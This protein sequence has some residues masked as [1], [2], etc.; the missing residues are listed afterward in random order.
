[1]EITSLDLS[2]L[3]DEISGVQ[4]G[5]VQKVYQ[6]GNEFT[7]RCYD[8]E[9]KNLVIKPN[10]LYFSRYSKDNPQ[11]PPGFCMELRK[12]LGSI[13]SIHQREF[14]RILE[15]KSG[16]VR[17]VAELF[18]KGNVCLV[19]DDKV[20]GALR[21]EQWDDRKTV[22]GEE[23]SYPEPAPNPFE[24]E[25]YV[26]NIPEGDLVRGL[27][28]SLSLGGVYAEEVCSRADV[29]KEKNVEDLTETE[30]TK[31]NSSVEELI[32]SDIS[33]VLY[34]K[35]DKPVRAAPFSLETYED[36]SSEAFDSF[37]RAIDELNHSAAVKQKQK[38]LEEQYQQKKEGLERQLQQQNAKIQGLRSAASSRRK[39]AEK[40][41]E[42][43]TQL[44][45]A[46]KKADQYI[47]DK[48]LEAL[49]KQK[50]GSVTS[51]DRRNNIY[52]IEVGDLEIDTKPSENLE[53][54]ASR[55][56][57]E[58]KQRE[59]KADKA[60]EA[61]HKTQSQLESLEKEQVEVED[62][63]KPE[64]TRNKKWFEGYRWFYT[65]KND[66]VVVGKGP[67]TNESLVTKHA[68]SNDLYFHADFDGAPSV[69]LKQGEDASEKSKK[70]AAKAALIF[71]KSW[72]AGI[73]SDDVYSVDPS[74]VTKN[75][76]SGEYLEKGSFV[77]RGE[78]TYYRNV[79]ID[80]AIGAY[81]IDGHWVPMA[82]PVAAVESN[83]E[84]YLRI[85]RGRTKK[86]SLAK[87]IRS[88]VAT[89]EID[90]DLDY[91]IRSLPPGKSDIET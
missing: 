64:K 51:V 77:I 88:R 41:Y 32:Y 80:C 46:K 43:Y 65:S 5:Y 38:K 15:I 27:A 22:V 67:Q 24:M 52:K 44:S 66:L 36:H 61:K 50:P 39:K 60:E 74:Q 26:Q 11:R 45:E 59:Q 47:Q 86:S 70:E 18:G 56:Y 85:S 35:E 87:K 72:K 1:M 48:S 19:K 33:P 6:R 34:S 37:S 78:R 49:E 90:L 23:H 13:D 3:M 89:E 8:G 25:D 71:S 31:V 12:H 42:K 40:I 17:L 4:G 16:D 73:G 14:D 28:S 58:A 21:Q 29:D 2:F 62:S 53:A 83:C 81:K 7:V 76:E 54:T 63:G 10:Q 69:I 9:K 30:K 91:L 82:G 68:D 20:I 79:T 57:D 55:L 84:S 75:A